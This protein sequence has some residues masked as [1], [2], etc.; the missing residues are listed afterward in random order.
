MKND[1]KTIKNELDKSRFLRT[2]KTV[3]VRRRLCIDCENK[4]PT[5]AN[6]GMSSI[7]LR[8]CIE[9]HEQYSCDGNHASQAMH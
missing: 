6:I 3:L 2:T 9:C 1:V 7:G 4:I 8:L 5:D